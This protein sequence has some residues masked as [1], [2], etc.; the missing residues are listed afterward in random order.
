MQWRMEGHICV[1][2]SMIG[3]SGVYSW[4]L[5]SLGLDLLSPLVLEL[6]GSESLFDILNIVLLVDW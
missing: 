4:S 2:V 5:G 1:R 3:V 6:V